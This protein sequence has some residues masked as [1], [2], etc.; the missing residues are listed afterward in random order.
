MMMVR[1]GRLRARRDN[2]RDGKSRQKNAM[3]TLTQIHK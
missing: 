1:P 3:K 2:Q